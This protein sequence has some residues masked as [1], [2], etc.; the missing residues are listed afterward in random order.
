MSEASFQ[1]G[2][3]EHGWM[4]VKASSG[5]NEVCLDVSDVPCDSLE[6]LT[7]AILKLAEG[8][9][10]QQ[11]EWSLEPEYAL[12]DFETNGDKLKLHIFPNKK[13]NDKIVVSGEKKRI[14]RSIF[15]ALSDLQA[16]PC[17]AEPD[18]SKF[19]WSW[20][21]PSKALGQLK[22]TIKKA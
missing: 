5:D 17:W 16:D 12:W 6:L 1:F 18:A 19:V 21:F 7:T 10:K 14:V 9:Q 3:P 11:V 2:S 8:S 15:K 13:N 20:D 4:T 22:E